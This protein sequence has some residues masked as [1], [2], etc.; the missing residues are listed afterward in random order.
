MAQNAIH[1]N[2]DAM[3]SEKKNKNNKSPYNYI[4][5]YK[6]WQILSTYNY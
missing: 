2:P 4:S 1:I 3:I 5:S 6:T